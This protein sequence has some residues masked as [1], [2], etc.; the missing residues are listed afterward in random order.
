MSCKRT[1][2][3]VN[4][5]IS[6]GGRGPTVRLKPVAVPWVG[7]MQY[8]DHICISH[9]C[10]H[11]AWAPKGHSAAELPP[12]PNSSSRKA[13]SA[14]F[15]KFHVS[16]LNSRWLSLKPGGSPERE[17]FS[18]SHLSAPLIAVSYLNWK[19]YSCFKYPTHRPTYVIS[20][21]VDLYT[22]MRREQWEMIGGGFAFDQK[23]IASKQVLYKSFWATVGLRERFLKLTRQI[24]MYA[25][26]V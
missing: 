5:A 22:V 6:L 10:F 9:I 12:K 4:R 13:T 24:S 19:E 7:S 15:S 8:Q 3:H 11:I 23:R 18:E 14:P 17:A 20:D 16:Q 26:S 2:D 25:S 1:N 21:K